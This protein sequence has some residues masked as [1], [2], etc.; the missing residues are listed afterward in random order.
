[1]VIIIVPVRSGMTVES[2]L[3]KVISKMI[4]QKSVRIFPFAM[5][6]ADCPTVCV[7]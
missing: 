3:Q 6:V 4:S 7:N 5:L 2:K 1:M